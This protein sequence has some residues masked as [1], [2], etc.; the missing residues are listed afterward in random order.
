M[1]KSAVF[2]RNSSQSTKYDG[3]N[4]VYTGPP[5][6]KQ[7]DETSLGREIKERNTPDN[8]PALSQH[9]GQDGGMSALL[10]ERI[11]RLREPEKKDSKSFIQNIYGTVSLKMLDWLSPQSLYALSSPENPQDGESSPDAVVESQSKATVIAPDTKME[12]TASSMTARC[13]DAPAKSDLVTPTQEASGR[14]PGI[15]DASKSVNGSIKPDL[16]TPEIPPGS[17]ISILPSKSRAII[18]PRQSVASDSHVESSDSD[19]LSKIPP[20][21]QSNP[22]LSRRRSVKKSHKLSASRPVPSIVDLNIIEAEA[23]EIDFAQNGDIQSS[24]PIHETSKPEPVNNEVASGT[25]HCEKRNEPSE[26]PSFLPQ[27]LS[28]MSPEIFEFLCNLMQDHGL[29]ESH[30]LCPREIGVKL[31][32]V[33]PGVLPLSL[34]PGTSSGGLQGSTS[35]IVSWKKFIEQSFFYV[36]SNPEELL[37]S[38]MTDR[39]GLMDSLSMWYIMVRLTRVSPTIV[40]DSLWSSSSRLFSPPKELQSLFGP[41]SKSK[42]NRDA[43]FGEPLESGKAAQLVLIY[44]HALVAAMPLKGE[45][46]LGAKASS[47]S[48]MYNG[49]RRA[50]ARELAPEVYR[51]RLRYYDAFTNQSALRLARRLFSGISSVLEFEFT[52][53][54]YTKESA[55]HSFFTD[56]L[57]VNFKPHSQVSRFNANCVSQRFIEGSQISQDSADTLLDF[58]HERSDPELVTSSYHDLSKQMV[59]WARTVILNEWKG[60]TEVPNGGVFSGALTFMAAMCK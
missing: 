46:K 20:D 17:P 24:K 32:R 18:L 14:N 51:R 21:R 33:R 29:C 44:L 10:A 11:E 22:S 55:F 45:N 35:S 39:G 8:R 40:F 13:H 53:W 52:R 60:E 41:D 43:E 27:T 3:R 5:I 58:S 25:E 15:Q 59:E 50:V 34:Q 48:R 56:E 47:W 54:K 49:E 6:R 12:K 9:S 57:V 30:D 36:L 19:I 2:K 7:S 4:T 38:F 28:F 37:S 31:R 23:G 1:E 42:T 26:N 16:N